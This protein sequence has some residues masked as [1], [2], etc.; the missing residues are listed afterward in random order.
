MRT[1]EKYALAVV[2][3]VAA[4]ELLSSGVEAAVQWFWSYIDRCNVKELEGEFQILKTSKIYKAENRKRGRTVALKVL[5]KLS[6]V[7]IESNAFTVEREIL[8]S[9]THPNIV[10]LYSAFSRGWCNVL[11]MECATDGSVGA[12]CCGDV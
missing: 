12:Q 1:V 5:S 2:S 11:E 10:H 4:A 3:G 8:Q 7:A 6:V 9:I